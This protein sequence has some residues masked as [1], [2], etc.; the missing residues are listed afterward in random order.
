MSNFLIGLLIGTF[1]GTMFGIFIMS[2]CF[3]AK[4]ADEYDEKKVR[5]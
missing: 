5:R 3:V 2:A 1:V 4:Q